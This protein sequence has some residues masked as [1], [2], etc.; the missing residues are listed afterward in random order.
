MDWGAEDYLAAA[1]VL[2]GAAG[3]IALVLRLSQRRR[4]RTFAVLAIVLGAAI[5]WVELAVGL[6]S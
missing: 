2:G 1:L 4:T 5:V 3:A 6:A